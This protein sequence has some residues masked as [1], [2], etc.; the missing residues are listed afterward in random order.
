MA[1]MDWLSAF[2]SA[3]SPVYLLVF[4]PFVVLFA[5]RRRAL[6]LPIPHL[7]NFGKKGILRSGKVRF[8]IFC[9]PISALVIMLASPTIPTLKTVVVHSSDI[10]ERDIVVVVDASGSM[11]GFFEGG[12]EGGVTKFDASTATLYAFAKKRSNDC[13]TTILFSGPTGRSYPEKKQGYAFIANSFVKNPD[14]LVSVF[15]DGIERDD[16]ESQLKDFAQGTEAGEGLGLAEK[17]LST[18]STAQSQVLLF[19]SDFGNDNTSGDNDY[20]LE[21]VSRLIDEGVA[22]YAFGVDAYKDDPF[23]K[24]IWDLNLSGKLTY[25]KVGDE[26]DFKKSYEII[27]RLEPS[28]EPRVKTE[29]VSVRRINSQLMW[30][31]FALWALWAIS[32]LR[33]TRVP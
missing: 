2:I 18:E 23:Y 5:V 19:I 31:V 13:F 25:F 32:E 17:F 29:I 20:A 15:L 14:E 21:I 26:E 12:L 8:A 24:A 16:Y 30:A 6:A 4:L 27:D 33:V 1:M 10:C 3:S 7:S 9:L 22:V 11:Q 28:P